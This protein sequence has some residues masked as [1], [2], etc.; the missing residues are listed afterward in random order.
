MITKTISGI[1][2]QHM[3]MILSN[4]T[5]GFELNNR[6]QDSVTAT[7]PAQYWDLISLPSYVTITEV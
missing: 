3:P 5:M 7:G 6:T 4:L 1:Q 2:S